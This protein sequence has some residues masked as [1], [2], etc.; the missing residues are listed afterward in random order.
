MKN[1]LLK[2]EIDYLIESC[3]SNLIKENFM[4]RGYHRNG[5][6][7]DNPMVKKMSD[8]DKL[9]YLDKN[10]KFQEVNY[11]IFLDKS[12]ILDRIHSK[13]FSIIKNTLKSQK[14]NNQSN[15][16][17]VSNI[18]LYNDGHNMSKHTDNVVNRICTTV[19][20]LNEKPNEDAGGEIIF[21]NDDSEP[22]KIYS[23]IQNELILFNGL[24]K[25]IIHSV[26]KIHNWDRMVFR[27]YWEN[28]NILI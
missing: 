5:E 12:D 26:N 27:T 2:D 28:K 25:G 21:Y 24:T 10:Q 15:Y 9:L 19:I 18:L 4:V 11:E 16:K 13:L 3:K 7:F 6:R 17:P 23:P 22:I 8:N 1:I 20:Y 14:I